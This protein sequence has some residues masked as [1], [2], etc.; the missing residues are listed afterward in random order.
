MAGSHTPADDVV[1]NLISIQYHALKAAEVYEKYVEDAHGH[2]D[3]VDFIRQCQQQD[4]DRAVR[5]HDLLRE[6]TKEGGI[7]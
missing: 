2:Q 6:L 5:A 1:Y 4:A 3:V 7:G